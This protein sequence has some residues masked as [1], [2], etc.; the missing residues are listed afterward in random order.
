M[1]TSKPNTLHL[2]I[3]RSLLIMLA[4][5]LVAV[6][7]ARRQAH[8]GDAGALPDYHVERLTSDDGLSSNSVISIAQDAQGFMWFGTRGGLNRYDG[9]SFKTFYHDP[10][11]STSLPH[12]WVESL[13][14]DGEGT[15]WAGMHAGG[16][17]ARFDP[18]T[19]TF[20][21]FSLREDSDNPA[22]DIVTVFLENQ[23]GTFWVGTH[24]GLIRFDRETGTF[25]RYRHDPD[26][27]A[28]LSND[29]V[30]AMY[31]DRS[32]TFWVGTGSATPTETPAG[33]GGLNRFDPATG[34]FIRYLHDPD[35]PNTL[36]DNKVQS[37]FE[38]ARGTLWVGTFGRVLNRMDRQTGT[39]ERLMFDPDTPDRLVRPPMSS[40]KNLCSVDCGQLP[41][42]RQYPSGLLWIGSNQDGL[43]LYDA[44]RN[45]V[46]RRYHADA[47][48]AARRFGTNS[49][50]SFHAGVDG[51]VWIG[52]AGVGGVHRIVPAVQRFAH[53]RADPANLNHRGVRQITTTRDGLVWMATWEGGLNRFDPATQAYTHYRPDPGDPGSLN[54]LNLHSLYEDRLGFLWIG[55]GAGGLNRFDRATGRFIH[56]RHDPADPHSIG[57]D[58]VR[59]IRETRDGTFWILLYFAGLDHFDPGTGRFTHYRHDP[60]D[61]NSLSSN[62][63]YDLL[64]D[65]NGDLWVGS[66][67]GLDRIVRDTA[68]GTISFER[69][70]PGTWVAQLYKDEAGRFWVGTFNA[71]LLLFDRA[72]GDFTRFTH[73]DGL[74]ENSI[75]SIIEDE[76][77]HLWISTPNRLVSFDPRDQTF[78]VF[79]PADGLPNIEFLERSVARGRD[80][81]LYFG[82]RGGITAFDPTPPAKDPPPKTTLTGL[83]LRNTPVVPAPGAPI[84][85]PLFQADEIVLT[86]RQNDFT[87]DYL[88]LDYRRPRRVRYQYMLEGHDAG[89]VDARAQRSAR[90][91][92]VPP[93][94]YVFRVRAA[95]R[96]GVWHGEPTSV[97]VTV[98]PPW[99]RTWWAYMLYA[100]ILG[101]GIF[102]VGRL[103]RKHLIKKER[104]KAEIEHARLRAEAA[105]RLRESERRFR[106]LFE[107][108]PDAIFVEDFEGKVLD[109]N[110]AACRLHGLERAQL[111][112]QNVGTLVPPEEREQVMEDFARIVAGDLDRIEGNSWTVSNEKVPVEISVSRVTYAREP[113]LLLHVRDVT[114]R[115]QVE[116]ALQYR[117]EFEGLVAD[118][119]T[120]FISLK[121]ESIDLGIDR[122]LEEIGGFVNSDSGYVFM[123]SGDMK[124]FSMTHLWRNTNLT[125]RKKNLQ[126]LEVASMTWWIGKL[127]R[128][129]PVIVSS[130]DDLPQE[131]GVEK[132]IIKPQGIQSIVDVPMVYQ[133]KVVGFLGFS[134]VR[135][136][137]WTNDEI[138]LLKMVGQVITNALQR[139]Q[140]EEILKDTQAQLLQSEKMASLGMLVAG[141]AHE[142]NTPVGAISS[143][144]DT[145]MRALDRLKSTMDR[146]CAGEP[147]EHQKVSKLFAMIE[148][149]NQVIA[150]GTQRVTNIVRRLRSFARIDV[151]EFEEVDIH[152]GLEDTLAIV[153]HELKVERNFGDSPPLSCNPSQLN[154]VYLNLLINAVQ[155]I[156]DKGVITITTFL[157]NDH[158]FIQI[159]DTGIG[160]PREML[161]KIFD[162]GYTTK[163][164]G[165]GTGLALSICYQIVKDH[166]GDI[167]VE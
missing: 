143:M 62:G 123:F 151:V 22:R 37:I 25:T 71:G 92:A 16:G 101:L 81:T 89:W 4:L 47:E 117:L 99:W 106:E 57:S 80:G 146:V 17:L 121:L 124:K 23:A 148:D 88:G 68:T 109:V 108:S 35:N 38:D 79:D 131:A 140:A 153:H 58:D 12:D 166:Q 48:D 113:A 147:E 134:C 95:S 83:R 2:L 149:A 133:E 20:T 122:A 40:L 75:R 107:A 72:T 59:E 27:P 119:S 36:F 158:V 46:V 56:Y 105:E 65:H 93:G 156:E 154:Q 102:A 67:S 18:A 94:D 91:G 138:L 84:Q 132:S 53:L 41:F 137:E 130:V 73:A 33:L 126:N 31:V 114:K 5:G 167:K 54:D 14:V 139:K 28:S 70:L 135:K 6:L 96:F 52:N 11:D 60:T 165:V 141:V 45:R 104:A 86:H 74:P 145:L 21:R 1:E 51:T 162:P 125:T 90:Y 112:G 66:F 43:L 159:K 77:G 26:D 97:R 87:I 64:E 82:G 3:K 115:K 118:I 150:S 110:P 50:W 61:S 7:Q 142:I 44:E 55:T 9:S 163:G 30:R 100:L 63:V 152:E 98:L 13:Y 39:F 76:T 127:T 136:R 32:G 103:Q 157:K 8:T 24:G 34:S 69:H 15:L 160:I 161:K 111:I 85:Q 116:D 78:F 128:L 29:Q 19:E 120:R 155:A 129:E 42:I 144:Y 10:A 164:V 49:A